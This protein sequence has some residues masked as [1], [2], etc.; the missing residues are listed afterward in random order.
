[1]YIRYLF[2]SSIVTRS[3]LKIL[4]VL[5]L[6][7]VLLFCV[8]ANLHWL[9]CYVQ[10]I[11]CFA[12]P[13]TLFNSINNSFISTNLTAV[14]TIQFIIT[15]VVSH[16]VAHCFYIYIYIVIIYTYIWIEK[17]TGIYIYA[18]VYSLHLVKHWGNYATILIFYALTLILA[19]TSAAFDSHKMLYVSFYV[20]NGLSII[21]Q[22][23]HC[24]H[25]PRAVLQISA[26]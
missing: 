6:L 14:R 17:E 8:R 16:V 10:C 11:F 4:F 22:S 3:I 24:L 19:Y 7:S 13:R 21:Y 1:M 9:L 12:P 2:Y 23:R 18:Y 25:S 26:A 5:F 20:L 15:I